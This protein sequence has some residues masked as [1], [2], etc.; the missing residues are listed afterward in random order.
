MA[1]G[2]TVQLTTVPEG[3]LTS[4]RLWCTSRPVGSGLEWGPVPGAPTILSSCHGWSR[5][6]HIQGKTA[7]FVKIIHRRASRKEWDFLVHLKHHILKL[8]PVDVDT[9][10][11]EKDSRVSNL[12]PQVV[13]FK[14]PGNEGW[15]GSFNPVL[16]PKSF[17]FPDLRSVLE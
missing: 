11:R 7:A 3:S 2:I 16:L 12:D 17:P 15:R 9:P 6:G 8:D 4:L 5:C 14:Q 13:V 10:V 1:L